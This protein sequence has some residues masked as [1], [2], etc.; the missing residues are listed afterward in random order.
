MRQT[1]PYHTR[2]SFDVHNPLIP[3]YQFKGAVMV[4]RRQDFGDI[5]T[6]ASPQKNAQLI[7]EI[8]GEIDHEIQKRRGSRRISRRSGQLEMFFSRTVPDVVM[9]SIVARYKAEGWTGVS[10]YRPPMTLPG[11]NHKFRLNLD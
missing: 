6:T 10:S 4:V 3:V 5:A 11:G 8:C 2:S 1:G 7:D 9:A